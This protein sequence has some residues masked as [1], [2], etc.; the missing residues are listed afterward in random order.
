MRH[1]ILVSGYAVAVT[2]ATMQE[3]NA[4]GKRA[5]ALAN[6]LVQWFSAEARSLPWRRTVDPYAIW[7]AEVMLQQTQVNTVIPYWERWMRAL[8]DIAALARARPE[9]V[10]KLWEGLGYYTRARNLHR[11]ARLLADQNG[12][13]FPKAYAAVLALPGIGRYTAGAIC[14]I[15]FNQPTPILDGNVM[16]VLTRLFALAGDPRTGTTQGRLWE[17]AGQ[18]VD[19][20]ARL[21]PAPPLPFGSQRLGNCSMLNQA[22]MELGATVCT[23]QKPQCE[24]CPLRRFCAARK[25]G[26]AAQFPELAPRKPATVLRM[27]AFVVEH[28]GRRLLRQRPE[29][30]LNAHLWELPNAEWKPGEPLEKAFGEALLCDKGFSSQEFVSTATPGGKDHSLVLTK[31]GAIRH[32]ITRYRICVEAFYLHLEQLPTRLQNHGRW[33]T[34]AEQMRLPLVSAHRKVLEKWGDGAGE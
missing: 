15:A 31:L 2:C 9:T 6:A 21:P 11:A 28:Q 20:A 17:L 18:L 13:Q 34:K 32:S 3:T 26:R 4:S 8:P 14:S 24:Q 16:R 22:L 12:G 30:V 19:R 27:A 23:P 29:G 1:T 25:L 33:V 7:V 10:L 5:G